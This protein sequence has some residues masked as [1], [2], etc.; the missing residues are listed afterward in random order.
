MRHVTAAV[1][2]LLC[3]VVVVAGLAGFAILDASSTVFH[4]IEALICFGTSVLALS[5]VGMIAAV[6]S[7]SG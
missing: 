4:E 7:R 6:R 5:G 2:T 3:M 1:F